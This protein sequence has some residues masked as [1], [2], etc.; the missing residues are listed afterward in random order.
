MQCR[1][2]DSLLRRNQRTKWLDF[3]LYLNPSSQITEML[4]DEIVRQLIS[5]A[6]DPYL[7]RHIRIQTLAVNADP[8][9]RIQDSVHFESWIRDPG[10]EKIRIR[11][12]QPGS[13]FRELSNNFWVK[14]LESFDAD[15]GWKKIGSGINIPDPQHCADRTLP[16][17]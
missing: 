15:P 3:L 14:I 5:K 10:S 7:Q 8:V 6:A 13:Y 4:P 2:L 12:E 11:D 9:L 16:G 17:R 1:A